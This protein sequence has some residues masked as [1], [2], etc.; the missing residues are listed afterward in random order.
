MKVLFAVSSEEISDMIIKKYQKDYKEIF[1]YKNV[2]Y[3]NAII[4][5]IQ[6]DK[7]YNR[8]VI[9]E[10]LEPF[11]SNNYDNID[12][13]IFEKLDHVSDEAHDQ[14]GNEIP[15]TDGIVRLDFSNNWHAKAIK[16]PD[17]DGSQTIVYTWQEIIEE[18]DNIDKYYREPSYYNTT[19]P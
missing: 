7:T 14:Y 3:Y 16:L 8:I 15:I 6:K 10:D 4:K 11:S 12:R 19:T 13:F 1:S 9:S 5:E 18:N 17:K 2:Y